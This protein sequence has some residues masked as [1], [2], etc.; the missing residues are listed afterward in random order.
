MFFFEDNERN[1]MTEVLLRYAVDF[2]AVGP[3][4]AAEMFGKAGLQGPAFLPNIKK[5][6]AHAIF[7]AKSRLTI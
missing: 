6:H 4:L 1:K 2:R 3:G 5:K 7:A